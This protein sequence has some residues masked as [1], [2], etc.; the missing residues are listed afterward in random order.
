MRVFISSVIRGFEAE[1]AAA[2][3]AI[4][5]LGHTPRRAEDFSAAPESSQI[6]CRA[7]VR[8]SDAT[9]LLLGE[10]YGDVQASGKSATHEEYEE[11]KDTDRQVLAFVQTGVTPEPAQGAFIDE[12]RDWVGGEFHGRFATPDELRTVLVRALHELDMRVAL[13]PAEPAEIRA[14]LEAAI[15]PNHGFGYAS[16]RLLVA[17][18]GGPHQ[19]VLR[20]HELEGDELVRWLQRE[21]MF[22][23]TPVLVSAAATNPERRGNLL[24]LVQ[25]EA[26]AWLTEEGTVGVMQPAQTSSGGVG[27]SAIVDEDVEQR[28]AAG[29]AYIADVLDHVDPLRRLSDVT[30]V[31]GLFRGGHGAWRSRAEHQANPHQMSMNIQGR[32]RILVPVEPRRMPRPALRAR[33]VELAADLTVLLRRAATETGSS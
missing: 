32:D 13:G 30:W 8:E 20:P 33:R 29:L 14:R 4:A 18:G 9:A 23:P 25:A 12:V 21:A 16:P 19:S 1:R 31:A 2:V 3:D 28:L 6:V 27:L 11:A 5:S 15:P 10:R 26:E 24:R 22:G 17:V 7:G